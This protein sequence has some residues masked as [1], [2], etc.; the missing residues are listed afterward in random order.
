MGYVSSMPGRLSGFLNKELKIGHFYAAFILIAITTCHTYL[1]K[2]NNTIYLIF[3]LF[4]I[5]SLLIGERANFLRVLIKDNFPS[6]YHKT[7][8]IGFSI[9]FFFAESF[10]NMGVDL[11]NC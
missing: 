7:L 5:I 2:K 9:E 6:I 3:L 1:T 8:E 10:L 11:F 4:L